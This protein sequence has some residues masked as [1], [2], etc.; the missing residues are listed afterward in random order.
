MEYSIDVNYSGTDVLS[1]PA[2]T[3][4]LDFALK[5]ADILGDPNISEENS[6]YVWDSYNNIWTDS[7]DA[8]EAKYIINLY[9]IYNQ[10]KDEYSDTVHILFVGGFNE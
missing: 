6:G 5:Y 9:A 2:Y 10:Y 4:F 3:V 7:E 1:T 8:E